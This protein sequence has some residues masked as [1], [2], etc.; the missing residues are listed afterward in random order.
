MSDSNNLSSSKVNSNKTVVDQS[1][2]PIITLKKCLD[3]D[4][5]YGQRT[6][7]WNPKMK[8]FI[9]CK[10]NN[11]YI[12]DLNKTVN[13]IIAAYNAIKKIVKN[14]GKVLFV[15][16]KK[17]AKEDVVENALRSGSFYVVNRWLG[18]ILTNFRTIQSRIQY[19]KKIEKIDSLDNKITKK[20]KSMLK[21][22]KE[23]LLKNLD[24]IK[25]MR[26]LPQAIFVVDPEKDKK[27]INEAKKMKIDVFAITNTSD[28]PS[29]IK[30]QIPANNVSAKSIKLILEVF[31]DAIVEAKGGITT[32][33]YN[34]SD[35]SATMDDVI[36][37]IDKQF[38][39]RME[40][41][42]KNKLKKK[43]FYEKMNQKKVVAQ[44]QQTQENIEN[45]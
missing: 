7:K 38:S 21:K 14:N 10:K 22:E 44:T 32:V 31:T 19:L 43:E 18:G 16:T 29:D 41:I 26:N 6:Y 3:N 4:C 20:E 24:G 42:K 28:D 40:L 34:D 11:N 33:A 12:F 27:V 36:K 15:N 37:K 17:Q 35:D 25:E 23:K 9:Y 2:L 39:E 13:K 30:F 5:F 1:S 45:N 8:D